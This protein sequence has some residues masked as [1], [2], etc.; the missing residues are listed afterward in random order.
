MGILVNLQRAI[1]PNI[2]VLR[3]L[4]AWF[5]AVSDFIDNFTLTNPTFKAAAY[6]D[7]N[8]YVHQE[9]FSGAITHVGPGIY[10]CFFNTVIDNTNNYFANVSLANMSTG[11]AVL[12]DIGVMIVDV[13]RVRIRIYSLAD[14]AAPTLPAPADHAFYLEVQRFP[15]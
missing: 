4:V 10:E 8:S 9:G 11:D 7:A 12:Y 1:V 2:P 3:Q 13:Q 6:V 15:G 14:T 5:D